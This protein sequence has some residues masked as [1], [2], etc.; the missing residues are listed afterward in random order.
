MRGLK[1]VM[2]RS[3]YAQRR[4]R[5]YQMSN[6]GV[7]LTQA[8]QI[9][10]VVGYRLGALGSSPLHS[11]SG[12]EAPVSGDSQDVRTSSRQWVAR[13][14]RTLLATLSSLSSDPVL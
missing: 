13:H 7:V 4:H 8:P 1:S 9:Q 5:N 3:T 11:V 14:I 12:T 6:V 10:C 2:F